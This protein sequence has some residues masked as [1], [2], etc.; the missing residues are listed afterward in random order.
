MRL[1]FRGNN[2]GL[3]L[4]HHL[5]RQFKKMPDGFALV[6][7]EARCMHLNAAFEEV[8]TRPGPVPGQELAP[9]MRKELE[10]FIS[11]VVRLCL[12]QLARYRISVLRTSART[13]CHFFHIS[14]PYVRERTKR[15]ATSRRID[16]INAYAAVWNGFSKVCPCALLEKAANSSR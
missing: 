8:P 9:C 6:R 3:E 13:S 15:V 1:R 4:R 10:A 2:F 16:R 7:F 5:T 11:E 14:M 12:Q